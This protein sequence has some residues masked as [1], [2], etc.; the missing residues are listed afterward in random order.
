[1]A[2][3][4]DDRTAVHGLGTPPTESISIT[5][6][7]QPG[8]MRTP[9]RRRRDSA[10]ALDFSGNTTIGRF[11][12]IREI[13]RGGMGQV[14]LGRDTKLGRKVAIKFLLRDDPQFISRFL[15]EARAT[16]RCT[17]ENIVTIFE[18]GEHERLPYMVLEYLEGKTLSQVIDAKPTMRQFIE[19]MVPVVRAL[20]RAHEHGIVH[21]DLKPSNVFVTD[22]GQVK[23]LDFGVARI[24]DRD[25]SLIARA[26]E[27]VEQPQPDAT[28]ASSL[29]GTMPYM[30]P[31][32][33]GADTVDHQSDIWAFGV[34]CWRALAGVHP[35]GS[36]AP[37][38]LR[39]R[40][41]D[42]RPLPSIAIR[43]ATL[44]REL[45]AI[46]DRCLAKPKSE[47]YATAS[48]LLGDLQA[49]LLPRTERASGEVCP[50]RG[51][52]AFG[53]EDAKYFFGRESEIRSA[54]AQL[55]VWPLLAVIGPS[56]VG[57]S[58]FVHAGLVPAVRAAGGTWNVRVL[59]PGRAPLQRLAAVLEE[60]T[61]EADLLTQL[62]DAPGLFGAK[63]R[64]A[65]ART[66]QN[67]LVVVD[68]LEE[69]FT[70]CDSDDVR[71]VFLAALLAAADDPMSPVRVVLSMRADFLD[72]LAGHKHFLGE[73]SRGLFFLAAPDQD[74]LRETLERPAELA[75]YSFEDPW[76]VED[77]MQAATSKG[78]LPL[79]SFAATKLW[80]ARD[81][82]N[83]LLTVA[84]YNQMGGVGGAFARHADEV[85]AAVAPQNQ[86]LLRAIM[87]RLVT[88][89]GTRAVVDHKEL[90]GLSRDPREVER[91]VDQLVSARLVQLHIDPDHGTTVELVHEMLITEWP[92]L[93][94][95]LEDSQALRGFIHEL[96]QAAKQ[97]AS[98]G[99]PADLVWRGAMAQDALGHARRHVLDLSAIER[100]FLAAVKLEA[101]RAKRGRVLVLAS[102]FGA[103]LL[104]IAFGVVALIKITKAEERASENAT[105]ETAAKNELQLKLDVIEAEKRARELAESQRVKAEQA[106]LAAEQEIVHTKAMS[107]EQLEAANQELERK[108]VEAQAAKEKAQSSEAAA[109][110]ATDEAKAAKAQVEKMLEAKRAELERLKAQQKDIYSGSLEKAGKKP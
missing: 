30:S 8:A 19:L 98:R 11:E 86:I 66:K 62:A 91:I 18:V 17:H 3:T 95:L 101:T 29:V 94:R 5:S 26:T 67:V 71:K 20:E 85:A 42:P 33:W 52:A 14:F 53:E 60:V 83:K 58:S 68:Q 56:G 70:L 110:R 48:A 32:Q 7:E 103:L 2:G 51:L 43:N 1:M 100:E 6:A 16:A 104:V 81:R 23:V 27:A 76:I 108:V 74:N 75:G 57:K 107:K 72:R 47:R 96:R 90:L 109:R 44:P 79:L 37:D 55:D 41:L 84:A 35:T 89:E 102:V 97:W 106:K 73:L 50:Y 92:A 9:P 78:A 64:D 87:T 21:R 4:D 22:R 77:M 28:G 31:E 61:G 15:V 36:T 54:L 49:F 93:K 63:L 69:L 13:A 39:A 12:L 25:E 38:K 24:V 34:L 105:R 80:E 46:V 99:K 45:V 40:V 10:H 88:P 82:Q 65:A 59:R